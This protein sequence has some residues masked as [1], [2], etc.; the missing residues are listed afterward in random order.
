MNPIDTRNIVSALQW[1]Y[2]TKAFDASKKIDAATFESLLDCLHLSP[3]SFGLQPWKFIVVETPTLREQLRAQSWNQPQITDASHLVVCAVKN[4][5]TSDDIHAWID[6]LAKTQGI[7]TAVLAPLQG[8]IEHFTSAMSADDMLHWNTR[9]LY[10]AL[11]QLMTSAAIAGI[12]SCPL[13]GISTDSY[14]QILGLEN[15]GYQ[16][17][18][19]CAL[20]FRSADDKYAAA[21]KARFA[22]D[23]VILRK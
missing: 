15:S 11:G 12:D 13:E 19:A 8:M 9:Q 2:A 23:Q 17:K 10:I 5:I 22:K 1:R 7:S 16:T 3:S 14:D 20:G 6:C 18:V 21:P 4:A